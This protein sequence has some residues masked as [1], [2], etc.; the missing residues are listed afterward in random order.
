MPLPDI[1]T[2]LD[3]RGRTVVDQSGEK[4]GKFEDLYLD[5]ETARPEWAAVNTGLLGLRKALVP[6]SEAKLAGDDVKVPF[7]ADHVKAA[8]NVDA[9]DQLSQREEAQLYEHY[10]LDYSKSASET[11]LPEGDSG[12][13]PAGRDLPPEASSGPATESREPLEP[14]ASDRSRAERPAE[15]EAGGHEVIRSEEEVKLGTGEM[16]PR[17]RVRLKKYL[18]TESVTKTVPVTREEIRIEHE[19]AGQD[20][21]SEATERAE[22][23]EPHER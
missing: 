4:I 2:A 8:P 16:R 12:A 23:S 5:E 15:G 9:D 19:P 1:D 14:D 20:E 13:D 3:W 6:L 10:G 11:G 7:D 17:E 18:V 22:A 21:N